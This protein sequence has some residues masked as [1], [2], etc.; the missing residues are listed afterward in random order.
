VEGP[1]RGPQPEG[2]VL[3][4]GGATPLFWEGEIVYNTVFDRNL[5]G[6]ALRACGAEGAATWLRDQGVNYV[7]VDWA[8]IRRLKRTYGFDEAITP[9][10][11]EGL[12]KAGI[13]PVKMEA[14]P[15]WTILQVAA[16][17]KP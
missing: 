16:V 4:V 11:V 15:G 12:V 2:K 13:V 5:L 6:D 1:E 14:P 17:K 9:E 10:A 7:V 3:L 8:E